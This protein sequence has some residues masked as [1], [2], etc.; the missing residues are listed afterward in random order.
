MTTITDYA[1]LTGDYALD[2]AHTRS[3]SSPAMR[4]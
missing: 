2:T 1:T 4:W 3:D